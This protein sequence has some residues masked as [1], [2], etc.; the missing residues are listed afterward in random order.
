M[1]TPEC[2]PRPCM[3]RCPLRW[4]GTDSGSFHGEKW[5]GKRGRLE[6]VDRESAIPHFSYIYMRKNYTSK[7]FMRLLARTGKQ[8]IFWGGGRSPHERP[9]PI[10]VHTV[11][12]F[13]KHPHSRRNSSSARTPNEVLDEKNTCRPHLSW[14]RD[15]SSVTA[16]KATFP[17][18][19]SF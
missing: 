17:A 15:P 7:S 14:T 1:E 12:F 2:C 8:G 9:L 10:S 4:R 5:G 19:L 3:G 6:A 16:E 18:P 11:Q 13:L